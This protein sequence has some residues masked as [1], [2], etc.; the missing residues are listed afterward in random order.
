MAAGA[1]SSSDGTARLLGG[2]G[3]AVGVVGVVIGALGLRRRPSA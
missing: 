2:A 1:S 3:L